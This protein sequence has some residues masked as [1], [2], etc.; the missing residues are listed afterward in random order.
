MI[1]RLSVFLCLL[2][3]VSS[4]YYFQPVED[5]PKGDVSVLSANL[6]GSN[7]DKEKVTQVLLGQDC[8]VMVL[9]EAKPELNF[10]QS[11]IESAGYYVYFF[12]SNWSGFN[13]VIAS[14][15]AGLEGRHDNYIQ[16]VN[17]PDPINFLFGELRYSI[18]GRNFVLL[19]THMPSPYSFERSSQD[20]VMNKLSSLYPIN[21]GVLIEGS[22]PEIT[23]YP[24]VCG[25][26]NAF[27]QESYFREFEKLG[28]VDS[29][30]KNPDPYD[31]TWGFS[32]EP[33]LARIDYIL[34]SEHF[35]I[36]KQTT[37]KIPG[38]DHRGVKTALNLPEL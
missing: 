3:L 18:A 6:L 27:P 20:Q 36:L 26:F 32:G 24:I 16:D 29:F 38:S 17:Y 34:V 15:V 14:K 1:K 28:L 19:G 33:V 23:S 7:S 11:D 31:Y 12:K 8:S 2:S 13:I 22:G 25:D 37:F 10:I 4:C 5:F 9:V 35:T 21:K 30:I